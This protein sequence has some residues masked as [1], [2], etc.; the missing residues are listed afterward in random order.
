M[1]SCRGV[2]V[3]VE[4][5]DT[6]VV[7][8]VLVVGGFVLLEAGS[9]ANVLVVPA[10][11]WPDADW[12]PAAMIATATRNTID[13]KARIDRR[14]YGSRGPRPL[15]VWKASVIAKNS[16]TCPQGT[17]GGCTCNRTKW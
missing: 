17:T 7:G 3:V 1:Q 6:V 10:A 2:V 5:D 12:H 9:G 13:R 16:L 11:G 14:C 4:V 8:G 15:F